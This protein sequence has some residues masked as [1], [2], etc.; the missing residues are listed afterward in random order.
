MSGSDRSMDQI[1]QHYQVEKELAARLMRATRLERQHLYTAIYDELYKRV[2]DHP[3]LTNKVSISTT[4]D[5]VQSKLK[6]LQ[7]FIHGDA[8]FM[9]LGPG[10]CSLALAIA[11]CVR[12]VIAIDVS[13]EIT[14]NR[15]TPP[16][17]RL[18]IS[19]GCS[20]PVPAGSV[21]VAYSNQLMEHLHPDDAM[22][23]LQNVV[24]ALKVGGVYICTTPNRLSGPHDISKYF[25]RIATGL[26]LK[27]YTIGELD[28]LF[29]KAGFH[30]VT[31]VGAAKGRYFAIPFMLPLKMLER[32]FEAM[33][34]FVSQ[35]L[36][37]LPPFRFVFQNT[38]I[39]ARK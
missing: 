21:D 8:S 7:S 12:N 38:Y 29:R 31:V 32:I 35:P 23:Q 5:Q 10:D 1:R 24:S 6:L 3:Q 27:E 19:D 34:H 30:S 11:A 20:I 17:Y 14:K 22:E 37:N 33:P 25:D 28:D 36:A 26:H 39:V 4:A 16:N 18:I 13:N 2:P 9:E 15:S